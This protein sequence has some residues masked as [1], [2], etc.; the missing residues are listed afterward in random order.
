MN[1]IEDHQRLKNVCFILEQDLN[2]AHHRNELLQS[3]VLDL[4]AKLE[5][6][7]LN[8]ELIEK[9]LDFHKDSLLEKNREIETHKSAML[10]VNQD[11]QMLRD[12][13]VEKEV[14]IHVLYQ[15]M[16]DSG[17][18][19]NLAQSTVSKKRKVCM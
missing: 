9:D 15:C 17:Y 5:E 4:R 19:Q 6:E 7:I 13:N 2:N 18:A 1:L 12:S 16:G 14:L 8:R 11:V 10:T 3:L